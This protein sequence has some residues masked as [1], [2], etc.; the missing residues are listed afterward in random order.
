MLLISRRSLAENLCPGPRAGID[1]LANGPSPMPRLLSSRSRASACRIAAWLLRIAPSIPSDMLAGGLQLGSISWTRRGYRAG[2][3]PGARS[4][5]YPPLALPDRGG[6]ARRR[7]AGE[8]AV[9]MGNG[10]RGPDAMEG[11]R[12]PGRPQPVREGRNARRRHRREPRAGRG[13]GC[14]RCFDVSDIDTDTGTQSSAATPPSSRASPRIRFKTR[15]PRGVSR[16][17]LS[18]H[19]TSLP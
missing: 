6:F 9:F 3:I 4:R 13:G 5:A 14:W 12:R 10:R 11:L 8:G 15:K 18:V 7:V 2:L 1:S 19:L 17:G 16:P